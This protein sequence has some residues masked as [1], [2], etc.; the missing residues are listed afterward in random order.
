MP[1]RQAATQAELQGAAQ[2]VAHSA[3]QLMPREAAVSGETTAEWAARQAATQ[4]EL[5]GAAQT[6]A[7]SASLQE[8]P[9]EAAIPQ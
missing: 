3:R 4:A 6:A 7:R 8:I 5:Q 1:V 9:R 2:A